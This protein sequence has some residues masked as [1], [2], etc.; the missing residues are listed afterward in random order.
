[1]AS[2]SG[3]GQVLSQKD[4]S[5]KLSQDYTHNSNA[6]LQAN[7][8]A[9]LE[10]L[11]TLRNQGTLQAGNSFTLIANAI[12]NPYQSQILSDR[13]KLQSAST[14]DNRG[15]INGIDTYIGAMTLNNLGTGRIIWRFK[16]IR[17]T[18]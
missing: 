3:D 8:N 6:Q 9:R 11:G 12:D 1:L 10:T 5:I 16:L 18:I 14:L 7:A 17:S 2:L 4:L 15:L 13:L